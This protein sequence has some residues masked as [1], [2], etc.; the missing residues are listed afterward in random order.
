MAWSSLAER[1]TSCQ[2]AN[3]SPLVSLVGVLFILV[4][5][6]LV[7]LQVLDFRFFFIIVRVLY[8]CLSFA[9]GRGPCSWCCSMVL[10]FV[11][12]RCVCSAFFGFVSWSCFADLAVF[13]CVICHVLLSEL[14][15][16]CVLVLCYVMSFLLIG[17]RVVVVV[18]IWKLKKKKVKHNI[19]KKETPFQEANQTWKT[20]RIIKRV[21]CCIYSIWFVCVLYSLFFNVFFVLGSRVDGLL[22]PLFLLIIVVRVLCSMFVFFV[23]HMIYETK[24]R[25]LGK[26][27][28]HSQHNNRHQ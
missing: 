13:V 19:N 5:F 1:N 15:F 27:Q 14:V 17:F 23:F 25:S 26:E 9:L 24:T 6:Y 3:R 10:L 8:S 20:R 21:W 18:F 22:F 2:V 28:E 16:L 11:V 7:R 4:N 12:C